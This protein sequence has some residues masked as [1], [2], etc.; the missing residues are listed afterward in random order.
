VG[1]G[2]N[3]QGIPGSSAGTP[4]RTAN[5]Q[6]PSIADDGDVIEKEWVD[7]AKQIVASTRQDPYRQT[8]ELHKFKSEYL[9]KRYNKTIEAVE[10]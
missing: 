4:V 9:Q 8:L 2:N 10:E 1:Q 3:P 5:V 7:R 6:A